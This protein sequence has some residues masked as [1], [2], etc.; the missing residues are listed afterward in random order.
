M[1]V[2]GSFDNYNL[3]ETH[4]ILTK[5]NLASIFLSLFHNLLS[6]AGK[7]KI[8]QQIFKRHLQRNISYS[9]T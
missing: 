1:I 8:G 9:V 6:F 5:Q 2:S 7:N 3:K 4:N